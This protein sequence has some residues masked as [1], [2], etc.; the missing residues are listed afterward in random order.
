M[1]KAESREGLVHCWET[2]KLSKAWE[3]GVQAEAMLKAA[4]NFPNFNPDEA[5]IVEQDELPDEEDD[6]A[7]M[8][9]MH[10]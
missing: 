4:S 8:M 5:D 6:E 1:N 2:T 3:R 9:A 7:N 10:L